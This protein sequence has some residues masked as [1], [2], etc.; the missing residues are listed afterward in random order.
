MPKALSIKAQNLLSRKDIVRSFSIEI[1]DV[2]NSNVIS[3]KQDFS[4]EFGIATLSVELN[5]NSGSYSP[6]QSSEIRLGSKVVL[7]ERFY[8]TGSDEFVNFTGYVRQREVNRKYGLNSITLTCLDYLC[9]TEETDIQSRLEADKI[10]VTNET[11]TP[12]YLP[13]PNDSLASVFNFAHENLAPDPPIGI[14]IRDQETNV[15]YPQGDGDGYECYSFDTEVLTENGWVLLKDIIDNKTNIKLATLNP[16]KDIVEYCYPNKYIKYKYNGKMFFQEGKKINLLITPNHQLW[17]RTYTGGKYRFYTAEKSPKYIRYRKDFPYKDKNDTKYFIL[18]EYKMEC[19]GIKSYKISLHKKRKILMDDW[20]KFFGIWLAEGW[21]TKQYSKY[22][23]RYS[24]IHIG[25]NKGEKSEIIAKIIS[26]ISNK[27]R[28][29]ISKKNPKWGEFIFTDIQLA[30]Y[31]QQFGK[32]HDKFIPREILNNVSKKQLKMLLDVLM[33]GDGRYDGKR[34][35]TV[36]YA[37]ANNVQEL[38]LK[39]GYA[40]TIT[41]R[42]CKKYEKELISYDITVSNIKNVYPNHALKDNRKYIDYNDFVYCV[43]IENHLLY[44]RRNG[45]SAWCGN[46][47]YETGQLVLGSALNVLN[48]YHLICKS[49]YFYPIGLHAEDILETILTTADAYDKFLFDET[50]AQGVI[51]NHLTESLLS[52]DGVST[53]NLVPNYSS[54]TKAIRTALT[55]AC[56]AGDSS[57]TVSD[58]SGFPTSGTGE[59]NGDY[60]TWT[61]KTS[62]T[63]TGI[64]TSG[65][66]ALKAHPI[67]AHVIYEISYA[68]GRLW[69]HFYSNHITTLTASNYTISPTT[70]V[71][72]DYVDKRG[73][74]IVLSAAISTTSTVTCNVNYSFKTIQAS[75]IEINKIDF[76][77]EKTANRLEAIKAVREYLPPNFLI[78]TTGTDKIW[79]S[80]VKQKT[81]HDYE[82]LLK[83]SL[84]YAED[85]DIYTHVK[86]FGKSQNPTNVCMDENVALL[87]A[88]EEYSADANDQE[89]TYYEDEG[90]YRIYI[91]GLTSAGW[92]S[93]ENYQPVVR[94]NGMPIDNQVHEVLMQQVKVLVTTTTE[95]RTGCHGVSSEQYVKNHTYFYYKIYLPSTNVVRSEPIYLYNSTGVLLYT[96]GPDD[97][98][99]N[100][101]EGVWSPE[102]TEQNTTLESISTAS[103]SLNYASSKLIVDFVNVKFKIEKDLIPN[104]SESDVR[105]DFEYYTT[106]TP[107]DS[108]GSLFD[109]RWDTQT[110]TIFYAKPPSGYV[111]AILD[112][113]QSQPVQAIDIIHGFFKPD[114]KRQFDMTN[115]YTLQYSLD[116]VTYYNLC[117]EAINFSLSGG[118]STSFERDKL[119]DNFEARYFKLLINDMTKIEYGDGIYVAAF[120]EIAMYKD[121]VLTGE[122]KLIPTTPLTSAHPG[123]ALSGAGTQV[124]LSVSSTSYFDSY[125]TAYLDETAFT[126][127][128]TTSTSFLHCSGAGVYAAKAIGIYVTNAVEGDTDIY[129]PNSILPYLGDKLYKD[130]KINDFLDT[131]T[132][133][134]NR[135]QD[136]LQEFYKRHTRATISSLYAPYARVGQTLLIV[137]NINNVSQR[138][139]VEAISAS[140]ERC[141]LT[142]AYYP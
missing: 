131:Q 45:K 36:S 103:F 37:L 8:G 71:T 87:A 127:G 132:K 93:T 21:L 98:R 25:Q 38:I 76:T 41:K 130:S 95:T 7:K 134:D 67:G 124:N 111:Y 108:A 82:L 26:N 125:G 85:S 86:F 129:D 65:E 105:A 40:S 62:T 122:A 17:G 20:L 70:S 32:S 4:Y 139:F 73:G 42:I 128:N 13:A 114:E 121:V 3:Y 94:I 22:G 27:F 72:I 69:Y 101:E 61:G 120:T 116:N 133:A 75:N 96:V 79:A 6:G 92:I 56:V 112:L 12:T 141:T 55:V 29:V 24:H 66:Y 88:G 28:Y 119:G 100:Y 142:I 102:G 54:E 115:K 34:C 1:N 57:I 51:D 64:P 109:G 136:Y 78:R 91:T 140:E 10:Q 50:S 2:K 33:M 11:L 123:S 52:V 46:C 90:N 59:V 44:V 138:Y 43:D 113:G 5:N 89:L 97:A 77:Y 9:R 84:S 83:E 63:L 135:A 110:Q 107:L 118:E 16:I 80:Y 15:D 137:D 81:T 35:H 74:Y 14:V 18:P 30:Q 49:Y 68:A 53:E 31:L 23:D 117:K 99:V 126:Y 48:N 19:R 39:L 47:N 58:T 60:F 104:I 106:V